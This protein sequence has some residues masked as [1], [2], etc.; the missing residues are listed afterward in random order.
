V[1]D[2]DSDEIQNVM[3]TVARAPLKRALSKKGVA[4]GS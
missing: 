2:G 3:Q 1:A 4:A